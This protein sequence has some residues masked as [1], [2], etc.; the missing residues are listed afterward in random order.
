MSGMRSRDYAEGYAAGWQR[1][2]EYDQELIAE[3]LGDDFAE[4]VDKP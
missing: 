3:M 1:R 4:L 2:F